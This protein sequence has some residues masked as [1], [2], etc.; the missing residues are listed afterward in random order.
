MLIKEHVGFFLFRKL[1]RLSSECE[2]C[3]WVGAPTTCLSLEALRGSW[4]EGNLYSAVL[5][6][7]HTG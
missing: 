4:D 6:F 1:Q 7:T 2:D 3:S 5:E